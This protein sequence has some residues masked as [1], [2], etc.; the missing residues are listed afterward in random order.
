MNTRGGVDVG[1]WLSGQAPKAEDWSSRQKKFDLLDS[2]RYKEQIKSLIDRD[3]GS[4]HATGRRQGES[5]Q[6][7]LQLARQYATATGKRWEGLKQEEAWTHFQQLILFSI[8]LILRVHGSPASEVDDL[9]WW[10]SEMESKRKA[11]LRG[12]KWVHEAIA[13]LVK[14]GWTPFRA[15][16]LFL[17][18]VIQEGS[19][20]RRS[21]GKPRCAKQQS[22]AANYALLHFSNS[23]RADMQSA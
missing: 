1:T 10:T 13:E 7:L 3:T 21:S 8:C 9:I 20:L 6:S 15:T 22:E 19:L 23:D 2:E 14:R 11:I 16:E 12:T 17:I 4:I 18:T 5:F